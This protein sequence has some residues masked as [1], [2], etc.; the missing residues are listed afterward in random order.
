MITIRSRIAKIRGKFYDIGTT[1]KTFLK[2]ANDLKTL[3]IKNCYFML[4]IYDY[5]LITIDPYACDK[6]GHTTLSRD[7]VNRIMNE[8]ARNPW[9]FLREIVRVPDQGGT[10][11]P[12]KANRGNIASSWCS[13]K[14]LDSWLCLPRQQGKTISQ[15]CFDAWCYL[16]G[17][18]NST[19]IFINKDG[20]NAKTNLRRMS[21]IIKLLPEYMRAE[22]IIDNDGKR[23]KGKDTATALFN[24]ITRNEVIVTSKATSYDSALSRARGLTSPIQCFDEPEFTNYIKTIVQNSVSTFETAANNAKRNNAMYFRAF[25]CTPKR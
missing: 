24:P 3:G 4:E 12:Y 13:W 9:Y 5:S 25:T 14:G 21:E 8:C 18:T 6:D 7:Q 2:V 22:S 16:F 11:V 1:N 15:L 20:D 23:E 17:T 19:F 10:S